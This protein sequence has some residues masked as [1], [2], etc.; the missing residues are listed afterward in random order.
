MPD[1]TKS[2][3]NA[4][5]AESA[6]ELAYIVGGMSCAHC[7][8]AITDELMQVGGVVSVEIDLDAKRVSVRGQQL[9]DA[10]IRAAIEGAGYEAVTA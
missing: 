4:Q 6:S 10:A 7:K 2:T 3:T 5:Q 9:R 1:P 8:V